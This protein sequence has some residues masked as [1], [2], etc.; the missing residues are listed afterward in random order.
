LDD[1]K[2]EGS[3]DRETDPGRLVQT[4]L[5]QQAGHSS[6]VAETFYATEISLLLGGGGA[7]TREG[8]FA[9]SRVWHRFTGFLSDIDTEPEG[10]RLEER[11]RL[12]QEKRLEALAN[13][14]VEHTFRTMYGA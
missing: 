7:P 10:K 9:A 14:D 4:I 13:V 2:E 5:D 11:S 3:K 8:Y 12:A 6:G 1:G